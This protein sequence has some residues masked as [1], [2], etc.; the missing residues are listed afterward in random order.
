MTEKHIGMC[1]LDCGACAAFI[2]FKNNDDKL[3]EKTA[4]EW[5]EWYGKT[6]RPPVQVKDIN[7]SGC[8]SD[9]PIY[10]NCLRCEIRK[11]GRGKNLKNCEECKDYKCKKLVELQSHFF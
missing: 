4:K 8:L 11:C 10:Q 9:G 1:G 7:C 2:A 3:R 6:G 5:T